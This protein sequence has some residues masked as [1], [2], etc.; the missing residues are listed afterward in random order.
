MIAGRAPRFQ[1]RPN[2]DG[3]IRTIDEACEIAR[4]WGVTIPDYV[5]CS[6]TTMDILT[7]ILLPRPQLSKN[8]MAQSWIGVGYS[9]NNR[10]DPVFDS[11]G[12]FP[13]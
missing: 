6:L 9:T 1:W 2:A 4:R 7:S 12:H 11:Q 10:K 5:Q 13:K 8:T 3:A